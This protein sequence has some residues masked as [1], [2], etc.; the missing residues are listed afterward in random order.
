MNKIEF[1]P[2]V[3]KRIVEQDRYLTFIFND[4]LNKNPI[5]EETFILKVLFNSNVLANRKLE[6]QYV[7]EF[8]KEEKS[9]I[10]I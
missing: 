8:N 1:N 6:N 7:D 3:T 10:M 9:K 4:L 2:T 5:E